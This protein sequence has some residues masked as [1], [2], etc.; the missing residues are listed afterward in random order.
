[1]QGKH[2][3]AATLFGSLL[4]LAACGRAAPDETEVLQGSTASPTTLPLITTVATTTPTTA[5]PPTTQPSYVVQ[6]GD[7]LS[8]IA[9][10][11][12]VD[13]KVLADFNGI[14]DVNSIQVGQTIAIPPAD[15]TT[16]TAAG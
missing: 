14:T 4:V 1:M 10:R 11:F 15:A 16:T 5:A 12:A 7:S 9:Q 2:V 6:Q 8:V 13:V 3:V